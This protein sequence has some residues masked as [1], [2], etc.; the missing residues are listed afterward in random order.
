MANDLEKR[1]AA[2]L[3]SKLQSERD[4]L[5][6]LCKTLEPVIDA[7]ATEIAARP[8]G[9]KHITGKEDLTLRAY[10]RLV[11]LRIRAV[12]AEA[13]IEKMD[14]DHI[15]REDMIAFGRTMIDLGFTVIEWCHCDIPKRLN[16]LFDSAMFKHTNLTG[17]HRDRIIEHAQAPL[18]I[19]RERMPN[20]MKRALSL[21]RI[22]PDSGNG[23]NGDSN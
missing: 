1:N 19:S 6:K 11:S 12:K 3:P 20:A 8:K 4:E 10:E 16:S 17:I 2:H 15:S 22:R 21:Y 18:D 5:A 9:K 13:E 14:A 23:D 7:L